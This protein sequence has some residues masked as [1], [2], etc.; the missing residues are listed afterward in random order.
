MKSLKKV[1]RRLNSRLMQDY[2]E[3]NERGDYPFYSLSLI[4]EYGDSYFEI[5]KKVTRDRANQIKAC[6]PNAIIEPDF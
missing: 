3:K 1:K 2:R 5:A 6:Y 4:D